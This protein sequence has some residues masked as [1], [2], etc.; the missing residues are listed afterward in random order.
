MAAVRDVNP[1][2]GWR[3]GPTRRSVTRSTP[4]SASGAGGRYMEAGAR[5]QLAGR[6]ED[7]S[8]GDGQRVDP[9]EPAPRLDGS[10]GQARLAMAL[11]SMYRGA[12]PEQAMARIA[13]FHFDYTEMSDLDRMARRFIPFWTFM[14][15]NLPL[16]LEQMFTNPR[17]YL[18]YQNL[19][20]NFGQTAGSGTPPATGCRPGR[21]PSTSTPQTVRPRG[22]SPPTSPTCRSPNRWTRWCRGEWD[23][24][25]LS[26]VNPLL[27][28][29]LE[30]GVIGHKVFSQANLEGYE[31]TSAA[32][33]V[34]AAVQPDRGGDPV[35]PDRDSGQSVRRWSTSGAPMS[36]GH[37][38]HRGSSP[39]GCWIRPGKRA[40]RTDETI[41]RA[42]GVAGPPV[43]R[44]A[45]ARP[46]GSGE[47]YDRLEAHETQAELARM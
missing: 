44:R 46:N 32:E 22:T 3:P 8:A 34:R 33:S 4:C 23:K 43:E 21:S 25:L 29:P 47:Y 36:P 41:Y 31:E 35:Q 13:K 18:Q 30:A 6:D 26:D 19:D 38:Y 37:C 1:S 17:M 7:V 45:A 24:A 28:A 40:G 15:R 9:L 5:C 2:S 42:L 14:S 39:N 27:L 11:N 16:Q 10:K 20:R 12:T